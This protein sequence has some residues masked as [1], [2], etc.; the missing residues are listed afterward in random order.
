MTSTLMEAAVFSLMRLV[1][2]V[3]GPKQSH[4]SSATFPPDFRPEREV[5]LVSQD[6]YLGF[7][8]SCG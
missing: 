8:K 2:P 6:R 3:L 1:W 5:Q 4:T 7:P